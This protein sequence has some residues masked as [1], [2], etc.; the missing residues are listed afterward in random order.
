MKIKVWSFVIIFCGAIVSTFAQQYNLPLNRQFML[1]TEKHLAHPSNNSHSAIKPYVE[2]RIQY[3]SLLGQEMEIQGYGE[4]DHGIL[5]KLKYESLFKVKHDDFS[6]DIDPLFDFTLNQDRADQ[7]LRA[8]TTRF[9]TNTRGIRAR[10]SV[11]D[12]FSCESVFLENQSFFVNYLDNYVRIWN[13]ELQR[14]GV[15][16]GQGVAKPFK[17]AG[18]DYAFATGYVSF[19]PSKNLNFQFG[20]GRNFIGEGYRSLLLSDNTFSYPYLKTQLSLFKNRLHYTT[21]FSSLQRIERIPSAQLREELYIRK[22]GTFHY[23]GFNLHSRIQL[24]LFEGIVWKNHENGQTLPVNPAFYNPVI[25][26]NSFIFKN[27]SN[28]NVVNGINYKIKVLKKAF[29]YGQFVMQGLDFKK[30]GYQAGFRWFDVLGVKNLHIQAE[31]NEVMTGTYSFD[32]PVQN[33]THYNQP[34]AHP[35]GNNFREAIVFLNYKIYDFFIELRGSYAY[36]VIDNGILEGSNWF[37]RTTHSGM[38]I[39]QEIWWQEGRFGYIIN[40]KT[41]MNITAG[42]ANRTANVYMLRSDQTFE[43]KIF[44][45]SFRTSLFNWYYDF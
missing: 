5:R 25:F 39:D 23:L 15:V 28:N 38:P 44:F 42:I 30:I 22:G 33:F 11:T 8:D 29:I 6:L 43:N 20:H 32:N 10:A 3:D 9:Y 19:S 27:D 2:S 35:L 37:S 1:D 45:V 40:R 24:G 41:N 21:I 18:F 13:P 4:L 14:A 16:P 17:T 36:Q 7:S 12:K 26:A 31:L 34:L